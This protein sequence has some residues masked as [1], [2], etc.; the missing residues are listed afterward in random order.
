MLRGQVTLFA[1]VQA[2]RAGRDDRAVAAIARL[3]DVVF[4]LDTDLDQARVALEGFAGIDVAVVHDRQSM[5][6]AGVV[7]ESEVV[8]AFNR[9]VA[10]SREEELGVG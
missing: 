5:R 6:L 4:A 10:Q 1:L 9:A 2:R 8:D 3:P 7:H